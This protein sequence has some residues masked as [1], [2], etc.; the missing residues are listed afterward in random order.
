MSGRALMTGQA[1]RVLIGVG[2]PYR[3]DD[4][5]GPAVAEAVAAE[6]GADAGVTVRLGDGDPTRLMDAWAGC[7]V[8]VV[9]DAVVSGATPGTV[10]IDADVPLPGRG[11]SSHA[12]GVADAIALSRLLD[13]MPQRLVLIGVE[14]A[15]TSLGEGLTP[16]V[17]AAVPA[18]VEAAR[19]A[20]E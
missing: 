8:A 17:V 9:V 10:H 20:L 3:R 4:G 2:N 18:A 16:E 12:G 19:A 15:D 14:A 6:L 5:V 7:A 13:R 1:A 11:L